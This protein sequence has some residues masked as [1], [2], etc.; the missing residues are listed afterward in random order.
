MPDRRDPHEVLGVAPGASPAEVRAAYRARARALHPD[1]AGAAGAAAM[2]ELNEAYRRVRSD[3]AR[4]AAAAGAPPAPPA[5]PTTSRPGG[6][7]VA[8]G[9]PSVAG[10]GRP[11]AVLVVLAL[12]AA[13]VVVVATVAGRDDAPPGDDVDGSI[14]LGSCVAV[15]TGGRLAE[16]ACDQPHD[17]RVAAVVAFDQECPAGTLT[18]ASASSSRAVCVA[19]RPG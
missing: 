4:S 15:A 16:V 11:L 6:G 14:G 7:P 13:V 19:V 10:W 2:A 3:P 5:P 17:G 1:R 9:P 12:V 8:P 18:F